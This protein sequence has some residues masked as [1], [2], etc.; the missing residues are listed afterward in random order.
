[1]SAGAN[2]SHGASAA[3]P[4][5]SAGRP[6]RASGWHARRGIAIGNHPEALSEP[7]DARRAQKLERQADDREAWVNAIAIVAGLWVA[8]AALA[9]L[10]LWAGWL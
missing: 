8:A 10:A 2:M 9:R 7:S 3:L 5:P 4:M 1:M 6:A